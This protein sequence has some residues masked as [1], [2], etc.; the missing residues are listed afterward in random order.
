[1]TS[2]EHIYALKGHF[3]RI[4]A[5]FPP[6]GKDDFLNGWTEELRNKNGRNMVTPSAFLRAPFSFSQF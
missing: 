1:M 4:F 2:Q 3:F 6:P 5:L